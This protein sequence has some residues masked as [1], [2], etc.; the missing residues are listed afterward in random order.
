LKM[1]GSPTFARTGQTNA[2]NSS[3]FGGGSCQK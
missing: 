3:V 2:Q 1:M